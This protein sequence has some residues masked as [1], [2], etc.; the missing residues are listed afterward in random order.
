M[1]NSSR[2]NNVKSF[3]AF[4]FTE[5][6]KFIHFG[7]G[8]PD[9]KVLSFDL[10]K[11]Y[12]NE[13]SLE[14]LQSLQYT[15]ALGLPELRR[16]ISSINDIE[17]DNIIITN[18]ASQSLSLIVDSLVNEGDLVLTEEPS[19]LGAIKIL[20][21]AGAEILQIPIDEEGI[22]LDELQHALQTNRQIKMFY[23]IPIFHNPT[24]TVTSAKRCKDVADILSEYGIPIVQDL[25]YK[26][27]SFEGNMDSEGYPLDKVISIFSVSKI[28]GPGFRVGWTIAPPLLINIMA[29]LKN[30]GGTGALVSKLVA[31]VLDTEALREHL[32]YLRGFYNKKR[33]I[34]KEKLKEC[35][36]CKSNF[37]VPAGGFSFWIEL[38]DSIE[39][40]N[41]IE[42]ARDLHGVI[43]IPG[44]KYGYNSNNKLRLCYSY[45]STG[46]IISGLD[47]LEDTFLRISK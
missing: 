47:S 10:F 38:H 16:K 28:I 43:I 18:G 2:S 5:G 9:P 44:N 36:L 13:E 17:I 37:T 31:N 34:M 3:Q 32:I 46:Q 35:S 45:L 25:V 29:K 41:Y 24:G 19:Y 1:I 14:T 30:D 33:D 8:F 12:L 39:P 7:N 15:D 42:K 23:T 6:L 21:T 22:K 20:K 40:A 26:G 4:S 27:I 11:D